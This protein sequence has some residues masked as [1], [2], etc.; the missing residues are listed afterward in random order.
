MGPSAAA[1]FVP[2]AVSD[3]GSALTPNTLHVVLCLPSRHK[4]KQ[5]QLVGIAFA[6]Q[7]W[8]A[9]AAISLGSLGAL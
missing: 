3:Y 6:R 9:L 7:K 4:L 2:Q 1:A 8:E 5:L